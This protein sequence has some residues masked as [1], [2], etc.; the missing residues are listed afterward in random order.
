MAARVIRSPPPASRRGAGVSFA[1]QPDT[2]LFRPGDSVRQVRVSAPSRERSPSVGSNSSRGSA[3]G[4]S[5]DGKRGKS[6]DGK[7]KSKTS[8]KS[9]GGKHS[10]DKQGGK[11]GFG[12]KGK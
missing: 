1:D 9:K 7:G 2:I 4:K 10:K 6:K 3:K 5:K 8:G 11:K 12:K